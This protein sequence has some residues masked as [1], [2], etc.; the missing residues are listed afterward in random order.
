MGPK[1]CDFSLKYSDSN[2][3]LNKTPFFD[4]TMTNILNIR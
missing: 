4:E 2:E 3:K 1:A